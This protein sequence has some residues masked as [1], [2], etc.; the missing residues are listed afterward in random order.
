MVWYSWYSSTVP[1]VGYTRG[2]DSSGTLEGAGG[3][4]GLLARSHGYAGGSWSTHSYYHADGGGN[5]TYLIN[6]SQ[7]MVASY[8]YDPYGRLLASSGGLAGANVYRFSSKEVTANGNL[9]YYCHRFYDLN[10][11]RWLN[12]DPSG[13]FGGLNLYGYIGNNPINEFDPYGLATGG[14]A[15]HPPDGVGVGCNRFDSCSQISGKSFL[16]MRMI[17]SHLGWEMSMPWPRGGGR[18]TKEIVD[19]WNALMKCMTLS[20]LKQC[21]KPPP[22]PPV[23]C[24]IVERVPGTPEQLEAAGKVSSVIGVAILTRG[25]SRATPPVVRP[26]A[27]SPAPTPWPVPAPAPVVP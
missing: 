16:L 5:V 27:P 20:E 10:L 26:P 1:T 18:H 22:K 21:N 2:N 12:R 17:G 7:A 19:L 11:Q 14:G 13:E 4:G 25:R 8:R 3:I 6:S 24:R 9:Y 15:Y 23:W